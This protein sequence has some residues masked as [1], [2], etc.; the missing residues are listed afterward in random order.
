MFISV[1]AFLLFN[2]GWSL[3]GNK[4]GTSL[5]Y[6]YDVSRL[7]FVCIHHTEVKLS[8]FTFPTFHCFQSPSDVGSVFFPVG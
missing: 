7:S 1:F 4:T 5:R 3:N 2:V 8:P 6:D